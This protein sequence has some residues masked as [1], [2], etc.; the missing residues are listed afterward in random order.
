MYK[1]SNLYSLMPS[2]APSAPRLSFS[3]Q[4]VP[5]LTDRWLSDYYRLT[6]KSDV[7]QTS[8]NN[9]AYLFDIKNERLIAAWA[10]SDGQPVDARDKTRMAGHPKGGDDAYHRGHAIAHTLGGLYDINLVPQLGTL[11][12]KEFRVLEKLAVATPGSLYF[13]YWQYSSRS[14]QR[15]VLVD[16]GLLIPGSLPDIRSFSN[17]SNSGKF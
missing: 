17:E 12:I 16:Q 5:Y 14:Q 11:N 13:T 9:S 4:V 7:V 3:K 2:V 10:I 15:P 8:V 1:Y 6:P